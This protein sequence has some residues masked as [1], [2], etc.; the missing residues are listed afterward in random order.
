MTTKITRRTLAAAVEELA[1]R[2]ADFARVHRV[3]GV[4]PLR[5]RPQGFA[6]LL[7]IICAQQ[8]STASAGAIIGRLEDAV[9]PLTADGF[10]GLDASRL[11][12]IGFSRAKAGY[13]RGL[14]EAVLGGRLRLDA[15]ARMDDEAAIEA[16]VAIKGIG[17]WTAEVYLL[18]AL[19][20]PDL[21][22][23]DDLAVVEAVRRLK[24]LRSR[25]SRRRMIAIGEAWRPW[26]SVAARL[27]WHSYN[28]VPA[29]AAS[30]A[31]EK[32]GP[33]TGRRV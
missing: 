15:V 5:A 6:T 10:L 31:Q 14:A 16:L 17:R 21:W 18:F 33:R 22:P 12:A 27:L 9:R 1:T 25:P 3:A 24:G 19:R 28:T 26:R 13:G 23:V 8:V 7:K 32:A 4:P 30:L 29:E 2:D 11:G 20:R